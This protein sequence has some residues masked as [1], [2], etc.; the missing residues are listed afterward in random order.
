MLSIDDGKFIKKIISDFADLGY[1]IDYKTLNAL[2]YGVPQNRERVII[3][4]NRIGV[5][6]IF[7]E[8]THGYGDNLSRPQTTKQV[9]NSLCNIPISKKTITR[10]NKKILNHI[11]RT[12]IDDTYYGRKNPPNQFDICDYLRYWRDKKGY[13]TM[14]I[15]TLFGYKYT[16]GHWFRKDNNSGSIP[17]VKDWKKLKKILGFNSKYDK[18]VTELE[19]KIITYETGTRI[20]NW[21]EVNDTILATGSEIHPK[22]NRRLSVREC[23]MIQT[24]PDDFEFTGSIGAMH[25]QMGNAVPVILAEKIAGCIKETLNIP[26]IVGTKRVRISRKSISN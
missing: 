26:L 2:N 13:T 15:D 10:K 9:I 22:A 11:A 16:A 25:T 12:K 3:I 6:N 14:Q 5:E 4:G 19:L 21:N 17:N 18:Q 23:A 8:P 20:N 7:P 1:K 24:F